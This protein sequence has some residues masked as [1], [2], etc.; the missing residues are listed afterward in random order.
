[1][2]QANR[3]AYTPATLPAIFSQT[4][5]GVSG[6]RGAGAL[7]EPPIDRQIQPP[8][9]QTRLPP[10]PNVGPYAIGVGDVVLLSTPTVQGDS[11]AELTGLLAA[12]NGAADCAA[13]LYGAG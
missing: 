6:L 10:E 13:G 2:I 1:M 7:P 4:S 5:G 12:Q 11:V 3:S 9:L 8:P